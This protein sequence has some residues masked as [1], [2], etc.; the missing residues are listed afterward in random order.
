MSTTLRQIA[1]L[2]IDDLSGGDSSVDTP[3]DE[4]SIILKARGKLAYFC[5]L[6]KYERYQQG[7]RSSPSSYIYTFENQ[8]VNKPQG[9]KY[10]N[11]A[12]PETPIDLA[13]NKGFHDVCPQTDIH[14]P[15]PRRTNQGVT[16][17]TRAGDLQGNVGWWTVGDKIFL[18]PKDK[19]GSKVAIRL[20]LPAPDA[21]GMDDPLPIAPEILSQLVEELKK[22]T[23][24]PVIQDTLNDDNKDIDVN[25]RQQ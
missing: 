24:S 22:E 17:R 21:L 20:L 13:H 14:E 3:Y 2:V 5:K 18:Y 23:V 9:D 16:R 7:D 8:K 4:R 25:A 1:F 11:V 12:I 15:Y 19:V 6:Q 10:A